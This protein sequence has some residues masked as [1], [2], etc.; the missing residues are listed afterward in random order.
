MLSKFLYNSHMHVQEKIPLLYEW[1][2]TQYPQLEPHGNTWLLWL[3]RKTQSEIFEVAIG[4]ILVQNTNWRNVNKAIENLKKNSLFSFEEINKMDLE[5]LEVLIKPAGFY[6][7]KAV[8]LKSLSKLFLTHK[9]NQKL[10][11]EVLLNCKGVG[12]ETADSILVYCFQQPIPIVGTYT[13][14]FFTRISGKID[15]LKI[16]YEII[17]EEIRK[18]LEHE[19]QV[20][21]RLHALVVCHSQNL[22]HKKDPKCSKCGLKPQCIYGQNWK[23]KPNIAFIQS[24]IDTN[25]SKLKN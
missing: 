18:N 4:T 10:T 2:N 20:F 11:R 22:C 8:Y 24:V 12:K 19:A 15:Y 5:R 21:G 17:Q 13:R 25:A 3:K 14:R 16:K 9:T 6:K 7:Q 1:L 23:N